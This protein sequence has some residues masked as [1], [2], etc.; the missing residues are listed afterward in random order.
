MKTKI[1]ILILTISAVAFGQRSEK[2]YTLQEIRQLALKLKIEK[3]VFDKDGNLVE[4]FRGFPSQD[5]HNVLEVLETEAKYW[6]VMDEMEAFKNDIT[7]NITSMTE[8]YA[9]MS[10]YPNFEKF[11]FKYPIFT[12]MKKKHLQ[13]DK[14]YCPLID[15]K[16]GSFSFSKVDELSAEDLQTYNVVFKGNSKVK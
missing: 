2:Y 1:I 7:N 15:K 11:W 12:E 5:K 3:H 16:N 14:M 9:K 8:F 13:N 10:K 6:N 4:V